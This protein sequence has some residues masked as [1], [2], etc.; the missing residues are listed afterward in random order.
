MKPETVRTYEERILSVLVHIQSHLD[1]T[2]PLETLAGV[3]HF[4]AYHFHRIFRGMVG[5]SVHGHIRR[6]R[7]ERAAHRLKFTDGP[8]TRIAFEAG[9]EA[10]EAFTR[11]FGAMFD[12][13]PTKFRALHQAILFQQA[14]SGVHYSAGSPLDGFQSAKQE[15][16]CMDVRIETVSP[17]RVAFIRHVGPYDGVGPTWERLMAWAG[18]KGLLG[19]QTVL[20]GVAHD[21]PDVTP[22]DRIRCDACLVVGEDVEGEGDVGIQT[23]GG[24]AYAVTRHVGPYEELAQTYLRLC[25][26]WLPQSG[27]ELRS[28]AA[29][30][31]YRN[32]PMTTAPE[33][34]ITDI[35]MPLE[36]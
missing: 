30:E 13:S 12:E 8:V 19:S 32:S 24:G 10:H 2:L 20:F 33:E 26:G 16:S 1:E 22:A 4:S 28:A 7:L 27:R 9:F 5:E 31:F 35:H 36:D 11:A 18:S 3:A 25:G 6:L 29:L 14:P 21:D 34:L 17:M 23:V 15:V